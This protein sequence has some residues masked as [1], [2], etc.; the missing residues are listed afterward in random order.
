[1]KQTSL[2]GNIA[3]YN[4]LILTEIRKKDPDSN[5]ISLWKDAIFKMN[6][7]N[8]IVA[9]EINN[10]FPQYR[11]L[12]RKTEPISLNEIQNKLKKDETVIDYL[13]SNNSVEGK[14]KLYTFIITKDRLEFREALLDSQFTKNVQIIRKGDIAGTGTVGMEGNFDDYTEALYYM[15]ENLIKPMEGFSGETNL[16]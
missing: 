5:K 2:S 13:L 15:Y 11:D 9:G 16:L 4:N 7:E 6:R 8:E 14:R 10:V 1:M 12:L 3:A